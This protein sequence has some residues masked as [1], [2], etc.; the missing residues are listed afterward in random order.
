MEMTPVL[1]ISPATIHLIE[2]YRRY[3]GMS[4]DEDQDTL[5]LPA[6]SVWSMAFMF[7]IECSCSV[8]LC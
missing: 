8:M 4:L 3:E 6:H 2:V 5:G 7:F 1:L